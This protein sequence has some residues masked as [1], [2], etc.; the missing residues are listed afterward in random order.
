M[1]A[2]DRIS[3]ARTALVLDS[4]FWGALALRLKIDLTPGKGRAWTDGKTLGFDPAYVD[5]LTDKQ[6]QAVIAHEIAHCAGGHPWRRSAR[7]TKRWNIGCDMAING[8]L[9]SA[10]FELPANVARPDTPGMSAEWY[11]DRLPP[12]PEPEPEP[13][14]EADTDDQD[15]DETPDTNPGADPDTD[16]DQDPD[17][18][19]D[20]DTDDQDEPDQ[21]TGPDADQDEQGEDQDEPEP[22]PEPEPGE[23]R[24]APAD[25]PESDWQQAVAQAAAMASAR[26]SMPAGLKRDLDTL[27]RPLIDWRAALQRFLQ[28]TVSADYAW[29]RPAGRYLHMGLYL[30]ALQSPGMPHL[31]V[32]IDTSGSIDQVTLTQFAAELQAAHAELR[33]E[34][35][36]ALYCDSDIQRTDRFGP[37]DTVTLDP[38]GGG[39]TDFRP[40]FSALADA[41]PTCLVYFTDLDG[42]FPEA[43]PDYPV[44]WLTT[45]RYR[46]APFGE[47]LPLE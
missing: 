47:T 33:P 42:T 24:D 14:P 41:P 17:E 10:G 44:L 38:P 5:T 8:I 30:P 36:T 7:D 21:D 12:E 39:G 19:N 4:P 13:S 31:A 1:T 32:A 35:T 3:Q 27:T 9:A 22:E 15:Q 6:L 37:F 40:V 29:T 46:T 11:T 28:A 23:V 43:E 34:A 25:A 20:Q 2:P 45:D 16:P 26:G 18:Q